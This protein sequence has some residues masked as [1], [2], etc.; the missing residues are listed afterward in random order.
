MTGQ[1]VRV[2]RKSFVHNLSDKWSRLS[3]AFRP[4][5]G[6]SWSH[7]SPRMADIIADDLFFDLIFPRRELYLSVMSIDTCHPVVHLLQVRGLNDGANF[8]RL[9]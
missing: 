6:K 4:L 7:R 9:S 1:I 5:T 8:P 2:C 3:S